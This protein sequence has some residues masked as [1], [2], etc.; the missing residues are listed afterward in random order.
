MPV[1]RRMQRSI[2]NAG[3]PVIPDRVR[4]FEASSGSCA[5]AGPLRIARRVRRMERET[6]YRGVLPGY[7]S[8]PACKRHLPHISPG[9][10]DG[11][12]HAAR[13]SGRPRVR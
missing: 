5:V 2:E 13:V 9:I 3:I 11:R 1:R 6:G 12:A 4:T 8:L 10:I 7:A